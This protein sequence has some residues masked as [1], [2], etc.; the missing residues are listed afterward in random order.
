MWR[1]GLATA[2]AWAC[3]AQ[4]HHNAATLWL[5]TRATLDSIFDLHQLAISAVTYRL[6]RT[7]IWALLGHDPKSGYRSLEPGKVMPLQAR[8]TN[9]RELWPF[10]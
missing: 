6:S 4:S 9:M 7:G 8:P 1:S 5:S 2:S 10:R 3:V